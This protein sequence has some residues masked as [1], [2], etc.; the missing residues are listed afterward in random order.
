MKCHKTHHLIFKK[1]YNSLGN[2]IEKVN[3]NHS[4]QRVFCSDS[5]EGN[6]LKRF[7]TGVTT[8]ER[9]LQS[10]V[11]N[12]GLKTKSAQLSVGTPAKDNNRKRDTE[13]VGQ[14][15][16]GM[17]NARRYIRLSIGGVVCI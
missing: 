4:I 16:Y 13:R 10:I 15:A 11:G 17:T 14:H 6:A 7:K 8:L 5:S 12:V 2:H 3:A 9:S 1:K